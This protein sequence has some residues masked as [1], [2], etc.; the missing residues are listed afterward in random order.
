MT[1]KSSNPKSKRCR[2]DDSMQ[3]LVTPSSVL[4]SDAR[5]DNIPGAN[6]GM[7]GAIGAT[8]PIPSEAIPKLLV[9]DMQIE[10]PNYVAAAM[11]RFL[12]LIQGRSESHVRNQREAL[13]MGA[14]S[15]I[16]IALKRWYHYYNVQFYGF[17]CLHHVL[18]SHH[19]H[20]VPPEIRRAISTVVKMG[21]IEIFLNAMQHFPYRPKGAFLGFLAVVFISMED[22]PE[23][24][25][26]GA[27][28][29]VFTLGGIDVILD[30]MKKWPN[31]AHVQCYGCHTLASLTYEK[32]LRVA[33]KN[34]GAISLVAVAL[35]KHST[36]DI[37]QESAS[38]FM[39]AMFT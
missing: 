18:A 5:G 10:N 8:M 15:I 2:V 19:Q 26:K 32:E 28:R 37:V 22:S 38:E 14:P 11:H 12:E 13:E 23:P 4:T 6:A 31:D 39:K 33:M 1:S 34:A 21:G 36:E 3:P 7:P 27:D 17:K 20:S 24:I 35:E 25:K 29:F 16:L 30:D 9:E